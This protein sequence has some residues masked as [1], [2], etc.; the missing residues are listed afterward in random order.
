MLKKVYK[1][2]I[3]GAISGGAELVWNVNP[4]LSWKADGVVSFDAGV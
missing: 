1:L 3:L 4:T 2:D